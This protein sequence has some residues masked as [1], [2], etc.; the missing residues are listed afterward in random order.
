M[1]QIITCICLLFTT[2]MM[3]QTTPSPSS[4]ARK[5]NMSK[6]NSRVGLSKV[7]IGKTDSPVITAAT[8]GDFGINVTSVEGGV[9]IKEF[10]YDNSSARAA[11]ML[12]GDIIIAV[13]SKT[14]SNQADLNAALSAYQPGDVLTV[15]YTRG[16]RNLAKDVR[17]GRK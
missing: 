7:T 9:E 11:K 4:D 15:Q 12:K 3:A 17:I 5:I 1:K 10:T 8:K 13:N 6:T 14:I 16:T 2:A